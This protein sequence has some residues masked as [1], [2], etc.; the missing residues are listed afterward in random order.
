MRTNE[1]S[2]TSDNP[3]GNLYKDIVKP[4]LIVHKERVVRNI[5]K[6]AAKAAQSKVRFRPHFKTHQ[7]AEIGEWFREFGVDCITVSSVDMAIY[8]ANHGWRDITI[9]FPLNIREMDKIN[10]LAERVSVNLLL[11]SSETA[12]FLTERARYKLNVWI[13]IDAGYH[14][15][16][17][18]REK[19]SEIIAVAEKISHSP[20]LSLKGLLT[21]SGNTYKTVSTEAVKRIYQETVLGM[22]TVREQLS[23]RGV[24]H[25]EISIGDTPA[26][27]IISDFRKVDEI[28]P[29]NFV[30]YD[31]MQL[32]IGSC[33]EEEIA[34]A[35][36]CPVVAAYPER[37]EMVIYG[38]AVHL[39]K[40]GLAMKNGGVHF[41]L[42]ALPEARGWGK[43][44]NGCYVSSISQEHGVIKAD[45]SLLKK[46]HRG[47]LLMILPVHSCFSANLLKNDVL[48]V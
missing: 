4:T 33:R 22:R 5:Q 20:L 34:V 7:S 31:L 21:H 19:I 8:F 15:S 16:G 25:L 47:D 14:R 37:G 41:G 18:S 35:V 10:R 45:G 6:I 46:M 26:C 42:I 11:E 12:G 3:N 28:R 38:G 23:G 44:L 9:A 29:G 40:E 39:S 24:P 32:E 48:I 27:S 2:S 1:T 30:F 36:A 13:E 17:I 43:I